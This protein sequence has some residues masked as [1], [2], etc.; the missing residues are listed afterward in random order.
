MREKVTTHRTEKLGDHQSGGHAVGGT[1]GSTKCDGCCGSCISVSTPPVESSICGTGGR[2]DGKLL[3]PTDTRS[4]CPALITALVEYTSICRS[5]GSSGVTGCTDSRE[6]SCHGWM[7][8][9]ATMRLIVGFTARNDAARRP[10]LSSSD[11]PSGCTSVTRTERIA[12]L[13]VLL[14][15]LLAAIGPAIF[16]SASN[17]GVV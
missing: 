14:V 7:F 13:R 15:H 4:W 2:Y 9:P 12:S 11:E 16:T 8:S 10:K 3:G 5:I 1:I 6:K 17:T